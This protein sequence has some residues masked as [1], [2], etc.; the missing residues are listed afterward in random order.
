MSMTISFNVTDEKK[1]AA[2]LAQV[3]GTGLTVSGPATKT[4]KTRAP[5]EEPAEEEDETEASADLSSDDGE[6]ADAE[7]T[8]TEEEEAEEA[9]TSLDDVIGAFKVYA[10]KHGSEKAAKILKSF[11]VK[12]VRDLKSTKYDSVIKT[13]Q[14]KK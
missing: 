9:S 5:K 12:S 2:I 8:E 10:K 11:G 4:T 1:A 6:E 14:S 7:E 13:L 3:M